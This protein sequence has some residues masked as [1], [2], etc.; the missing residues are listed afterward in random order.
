MLLHL[1]KCLHYHSF[2]ASLHISDKPNTI[3]PRVGCRDAVCGIVGFAASALVKSTFRRA[4]RIWC[5][6]ILPPAKAPSR[7]PVAANGPR[8]EKVMVATQNPPK[9]HDGKPPY[10]LVWPLHAI[11]GRDFRWLRDNGWDEVSRLGVQIIA[12]SGI[13]SG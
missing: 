8:N 4:L 3:S 9:L 11:Y 13:Y 10:L 1:Q 6:R 5:C 7:R 2:V 12:V